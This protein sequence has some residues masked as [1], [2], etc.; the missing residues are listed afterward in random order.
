LIKIV[1]PTKIKKLALCA[2]MGPSVKIVIEK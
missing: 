1:K 2:T